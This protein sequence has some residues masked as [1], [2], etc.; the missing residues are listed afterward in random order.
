MTASAALPHRSAS[1]VV[2][3]AV[4]SVT[5]LAIAAMLFADVTALPLLIALLLIAVAATA[6]AIVGFVRRRSTGKPNGALVVGLLSPAIALSAMTPL[7]AVAGAV[8]FAVFAVITAVETA[9][10]AIVS[11]RGLNRV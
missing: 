9:V 5:W 11:F 10:L 3:P 1:E 7:F 6:I 4:A 8:V 2:V